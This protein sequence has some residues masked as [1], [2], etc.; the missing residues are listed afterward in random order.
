MNTDLVSR[1]QRGDS[2]AWES[3]YDAHARALR[4]YITRL[5]ARDADDVLGETMVQVVRDIKKFR[6]DDDG[7]RPWAFRIAHHRV[8][9]AARSRARQPVE[10]TD[11]L[12]DSSTSE[13]ASTSDMAPLTAVPDLGELSALLD[14]LTPDQRSAVWLRHVEDFS[15]EDAARILDKTPDAVAALTFRGLRQLRKML[16]T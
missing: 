16:D 6:G 8:I 2:R 12:D 5:G 15:V 14:K 11:S 9:D 13:T 3:F 1:L 7:L 10:V 4:S